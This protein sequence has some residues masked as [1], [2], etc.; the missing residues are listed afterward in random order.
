M[1]LKPLS[2]ATTTPPFSPLPTPSPPLFIEDDVSSRA[3]PLQAFLFSF[4]NP[5]T[6]GFDAPTT[7]EAAIQAM[8]AR[9]DIRLQLTNGDEEDKEDEDEEDK[10]EEDEVGEIDANHA[11]NGDYSPPDDWMIDDVNDQDDDDDNEDGGS[12]DDDLLEET[13]AMLA[14]SRCGDRTSAPSSEA[15]SDLSDA[16]SSSA[17]STRQR[18]ETEGQL[19]ATKRRRFGLTDASSSLR[20]STSGLGSSSNLL[21][22]SPIVA[23]SSASTAA[24]APSAGQPPP[25]PPPPAPLAISAHLAN[26]QQPPAV[27]LPAGTV[28]ACRTD[29][30]VGARRPVKV[31]VGFRTGHVH[32]YIA[33]ESVQKLMAWCT[34][35]QTLS[36]R[37][38]ARSTW[39]GA[40]AV[41]L[42]KPEPI[43]LKF[44]VHNFGAQHRQYLTWPDCAPYTKKYKLDVILGLEALCAA[45]FESSGSYYLRTDCNMLLSR[46]AKLPPR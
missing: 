16:P 24:V 17:T 1:T 19:P 7:E 14:T 29:L 6:A 43:G 4:A 22:S 40:E 46:V 38:T 45:V 26:G 33:P 21:P 27:H 28:F 3:S 32:H 30:V 44:R 2:S 5:I 37:F 42:R 10:D 8:E 36:L 18:T 12:S 31:V 20:V 39:K 25:P 11:S 13:S 9:L 34:S 15:S 41:A 35:E 23:M